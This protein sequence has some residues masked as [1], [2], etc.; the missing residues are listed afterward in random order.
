MSTAHDEDAGVGDVD[1]VAGGQ[2]RG[3]GVP[4]AGSGLLVPHQTTFAPF[5]L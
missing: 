5:A 4:L 3:R 1:G 2:Q